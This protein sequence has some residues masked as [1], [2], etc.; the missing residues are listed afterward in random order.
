M[1]RRRIPDYTG[2]SK[3]SK[4]SEGNPK[5]KDELVM[6]NSKEILGK[7]NNA[8]ILSPERTWSIW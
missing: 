1:I 7:R 4:R 2:G 8:N 6:R 5:I 3:A